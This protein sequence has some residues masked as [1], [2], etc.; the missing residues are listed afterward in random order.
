MRR[1]CTHSLYSRAV[2]CHNPNL[3]DRVQCCATDRTSPVPLLHLESFLPLVL[4][5]EEEDREGKQVTRNDVLCMI[6]GQRTSTRT[7]GICICRRPSAG[8]S[9]RPAGHACCST[10]TVAFCSLF[11]V[12]T[13]KHTHPSFCQCR[14]HVERFWS[15][16][17]AKEEARLWRSMHCALSPSI[18]PTAIAEPPQ[19]CREKKISCDGVRPLC[20]G[21][22]ETGE[23]CRPP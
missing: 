18:L 14:G 7:A 13:N 11:R 19:S 5:Y 2:P 16:R 22:K 17:P 4:P 15:S 12:Q 21:C 6:T 10:R 8:S 20:G 23:D 9:D 1:N 3:M